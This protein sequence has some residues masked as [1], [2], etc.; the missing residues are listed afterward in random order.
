MPS[1]Q[2]LEVQRDQLYMR[3]SSVKSTHP[4]RQGTQT[5]VAAGWADQWCW[6]T[7]MRQTQRIRCQV[8]RIPEE[9]H[10]VHGWLLSSLCSHGHT[11]SCSQRPSPLITPPSPNIPLIIPIGY[12]CRPSW[13]SELSAGI[14]H[15][16]YGHMHG[17]GD[18]GQQPWA[19]ASQPPCTPALVQA[20]H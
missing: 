15:Q 5:T 19:R 10:C 16:E 12:A 11:P 17:C 20:L 18:R 3:Q 2:S 4:Q 1:L 6:Q 9:Q 7:C 13:H 14:C 8:G